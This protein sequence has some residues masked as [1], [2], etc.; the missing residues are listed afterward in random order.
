MIISHQLELGQ[1]LVSL[2]LAAQVIR[3]CT[4]H[5]KDYIYI[6]RMNGLND[7]SPWMTYDYYH[8]SCYDMHVYYF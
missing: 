5:C 1:D 6:Y 3:K 4:A 8:Y 7:L 2:V